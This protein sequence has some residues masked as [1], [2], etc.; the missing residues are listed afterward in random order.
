MAVWEK[1]LWG[2][3]TGSEKPWGWSRLSIIKCETG[4]ACLG[5]RQYGETRKKWIRSE[6]GGRSSRASGVGLDTWLSSTLR[7]VRSHWRALTSGTASSDL[8]FP[9][10]ALAALCRIDYIRENRS[11]GSSLGAWT[12]IETM[13]ITNRIW[14]NPEARVEEILTIPIYNIECIH[15]QRSKKLKISWFVRKCFPLVLWQ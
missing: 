9:K 4:L 13:E 11:W 12:G 8:Q 7:V 2:E 15:Y 5:Q 14:G 6:T 3:G 1:L 10:V